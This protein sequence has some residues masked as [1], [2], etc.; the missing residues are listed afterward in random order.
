MNIKDRMHNITNALSR[1]S[2][3]KTFIGLL[4]RMTDTGDKSYAELENITRLLE[5]TVE[6]NEEMLRVMRPGRWKK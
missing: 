4:Q 1:T 2:L 5:K 6:Q 3:Y